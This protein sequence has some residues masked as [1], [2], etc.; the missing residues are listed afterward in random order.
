MDS[1]QT[2]DEKKKKPQDVSMTHF[3]LMNVRIYL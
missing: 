1:Y 2:N 3:E